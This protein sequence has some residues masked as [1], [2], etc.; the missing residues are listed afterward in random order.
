MAE[1]EYHIIYHILPFVYEIPYR[2]AACL[3][4]QRR[5]EKQSRDESGV[6]YVP[7]WRAKNFGG[8]ERLFS[9]I[10]C[11]V[12][13]QEDPRR[14]GQGFILEEGARKAY[15]LPPGSSQSI[16]FKKNDKTFQFHIPQIELYLFESQIGFLIYQVQFRNHEFLE[17]CEENY[18][19]KNLYQNRNSFFMEQFVNGM[20]SLMPCPLHESME[21]LLSVLTVSTYFENND[22]YPKQS[23]IYQCICLKQKPNDSVLSEGFFYM[24]YAFKSTYQMYDTQWLEKNRDSCFSIFANSLWG[25]SLESLANL[26]WLTDESGTDTFFKGNYRGNIKNSYF[27]IYLLTLNQRYS[28]LHYLQKGAAIRRVVSPKES[29]E[30]IVAYIRS[31]KEEIAYF[32]LRGIY[33]EISNVTVQSVLYDHLLRGLFVD[34]MK[35]ELNGEL[36]SLQKILEERENIIRQRQEERLEKNR[37]Y[38]TAFIAILSF[39]FVVIEAVNTVWDMCLKAMDQKLPDS[40]SLW[41]YVLFGGSGVVCGMVLLAAGGYIWNYLNEKKKGKMK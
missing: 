3:I 4:S 11:L 9:H 1:T 7:E 40:G 37:R 18:Y 27:Y 29:G 19:V 38:F 12:S 16:T 30:S 31:L 17:I 14:I 23:L 10:N 39:V 15:G 5:L 22:A 35:D 41:Y 36:E 34:R 20:K 13:E 21:K 32:Q 33:H 6:W 25:V 2:E 28:L 24:Q 8:R 26:V